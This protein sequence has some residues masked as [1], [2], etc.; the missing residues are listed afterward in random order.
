MIAVLST[1]NNKKFGQKII[2]PD[3]FQ[4]NAAQD[5]HIIAGRYEQ[6]YLLH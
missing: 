5:I 2:Q 4:E 6:G 1:S 3:P